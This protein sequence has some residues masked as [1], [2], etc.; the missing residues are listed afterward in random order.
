MMGL[1]CRGYVAGQVLP[2]FRLVDS[3]SLIEMLR[4][5]VSSVMLLRA[6]TF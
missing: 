5:R 3:F 6:M 2:F 1:K 4:G